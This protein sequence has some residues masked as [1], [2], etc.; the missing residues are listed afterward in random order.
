MGEL[1]LFVIQYCSHVKLNNLHAPSYGIAYDGYSHHIYDTD[2]H[3]SFNLKSYICSVY[4]Q[5]K[6]MVQKKI[7]LKN[8]N[9]KTKII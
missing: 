2:G 4:S 9:N 6:L 5:Y 3:L 1:H 7:A 8:N